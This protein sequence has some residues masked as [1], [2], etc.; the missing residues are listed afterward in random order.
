M[1]SMSRFTPASP[2][3]VEGY[4]Q[5]PALGRLEFG[6]VVAIAHTADAHVMVFDMR[7]PGDDASEDEIGWVA[8][9]SSSETASREKHSRAFPRMDG[10]SPVC[11]PGLQSVDGCL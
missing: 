10:A 5:C 1:K 7:L 8:V 9:P 4:P 2:G 3:C 6:V 11:I